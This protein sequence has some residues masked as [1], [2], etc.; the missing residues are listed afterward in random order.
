MQ[1]STAVF[2][3]LVV[4]HAAAVVLPFE[5]AMSVM[6]WS[7]QA[8]AISG[9]VAMFMFLKSQKVGL[10][11]S[12]AVVLVTTIV[13]ALA[14]LAISACRSIQE[15]KKSFA[16]H[17]LVF[18]LAGMAGSTAFVGF[19]VGSAAGL[20]AWGAI[21]AALVVVPLYIVHVMPVV[22]RGVVS[23]LGSDA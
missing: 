1:T 3:A 4:I 10:G 5:W 19:S 15:C 23:V 21:V 20:P 2:L 9:A 6:G 7:A 11:Y 18:A 16:L 12:A 14:A 13:S 22:T 8:V 17:S